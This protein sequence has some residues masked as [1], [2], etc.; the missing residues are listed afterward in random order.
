MQLTYHRMSNSLDGISHCRHIICNSYVHYMFF[1][2]SNNAHC[3]FWNILMSIEL[4]LINLK[5]DFNVDV[6]WAKWN[7]EKH[8]MKSVTKISIYT[9]KIEQKRNILMLCMHFNVQQLFRKTKLQLQRSFILSVTNSI[10][11]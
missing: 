11:I 1:L 4:P 6:H 5:A 3:Y 10:I 8:I 7:N 9:R 2:A